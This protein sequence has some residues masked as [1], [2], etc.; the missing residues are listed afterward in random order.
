MSTIAF[1][2]TA[3]FAGIELEIETWTESIGR[4]VIRHQPTRGDGAQLFDRGRVPRTYNLSLRLTGTATVVTAKRAALVALATSGETRVFEH[5]LD[6]IVRCKLEAFDG[7]VAAGNVTYTAVLVE[8]LAFTRRIAVS[9]QAD[10]ASIQDVVIT[11]IELAEAI[12]FLTL[13]NVP[14]IEGAVAKAQTWTERAQS[15]IVADVEAMR[16]DVLELRRAL[17]ATS[18]LALYQASVALETFRGT[19]ERY[20]QVVNDIQGATFSL[21]VAQPLPLIVVLTALYGAPLAESVAAE[22]SRINNV[23]NAG[24]LAVG[25][26]LTL[27]AAVV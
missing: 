8:D 25:Q 17:D 27:P 23:V 21:N 11:G 16:A 19:Y 15:D 13:G 14:D 26:V 10:E 18:D 1:T 3:R 6:G 7:S 5:P 20:A 12:E 4:T 24:R 22:V 9:Q 2:F